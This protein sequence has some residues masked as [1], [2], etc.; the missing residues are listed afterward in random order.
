MLKHINRLT[1]NNSHKQGRQVDPILFN[2]YHFFIPIKEEEIN[3]GFQSK[4]MKDETHEKKCHKTANNVL[5]DKTTNNV[6]DETHE[7][8]M[9]QNNKIRQP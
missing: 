8:K 5:K 4:H 9:S 1:Q 3:L 2:L 7:E 6:K